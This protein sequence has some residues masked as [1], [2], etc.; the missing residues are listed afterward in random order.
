MLFLLLVRLVHPVDKTD[1]A[2]GKVVMRT[3]CHGNQVE[4]DEV[5]V[6][7]LK[8]LAIG[9]HGEVLHPKYS[10]PIENGGYTSWKI[11]DCLKAQ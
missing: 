1:V 9:E 11:M 8:L 7:V 10:Y 6:V 4:N 2:E 5:A 3:V